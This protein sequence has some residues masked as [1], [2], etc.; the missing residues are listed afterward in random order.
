MYGFL[1]PPDIKGL[2]LIYIDCN[3]ITLHFITLQILD[4]CVIWSFFA[5][6]PQFDLISI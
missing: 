2:K 3:F 1:L 5:P 6:F 4:I